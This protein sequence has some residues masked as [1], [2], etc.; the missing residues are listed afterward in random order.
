MRPKTKAL[1][2][3]FS[4]QPLENLFPNFPDNEHLLR[5]EQVTF[6]SDLTTIQDDP[7]FDPASGPRWLTHVRMN[8]GVLRNNF[9]TGP[10][11]YQETCGGT[12]NRW[13]SVR[14]NSS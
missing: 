1:E 5:R 4:L 6:T 8:G 2:S 11:V 9:M 10:A 7:D 3:C 12:S 14:E 13:L